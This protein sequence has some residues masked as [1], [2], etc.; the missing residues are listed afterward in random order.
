MRQ[1]VDGLD[2]LIRRRAVFERTSMTRYMIDLQEELGFFPNA[3][4]LGQSMKANVR[5]A[6]G[7]KRD[8][9]TA[10][11]W[12]PVFESPVLTNINK[13]A[14]FKIFAVV[15]GTKSINIA[16][17]RVGRLTPMV[18][19]VTGVMG[20]EQLN[21]FLSGQIKGLAI[22]LK[23]VYD[24]E[25]LMETKYPGEINIDKGPKYI[26]ALHIGIGL[27]ILAIVAGNVGVFLTR[28]QG[29]A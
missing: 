2:R 6:F 26:F 12:R 9:N 27:M 16:M 4:A 20:P 10:G 11:D 29:A 17:E 3:E 18:G 5:N 8:A 21:Y 15:T 1:T 23:G 24:L 13:M 22:G 25:G 19:M 7:S 28:K 14:D